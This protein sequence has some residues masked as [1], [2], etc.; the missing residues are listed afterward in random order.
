MFSAVLRLANSLSI[1][2]RRVTRHR[3]FAC[4]ILLVVVVFKK[5]AFCIAAAT[6][7]RSG[8]DRDRQADKAF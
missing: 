7:A 2:P 8:T 4:R 3:L 6:G 5:S 1:L